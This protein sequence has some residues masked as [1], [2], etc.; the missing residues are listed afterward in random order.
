MKIAKL[1]ASLCI[2]ASVFLIGVTS[3]S[4]RELKLAVGFPQGT[5]AYYGLEVFGK[6]LK[7]KSGGELEV[8]LFPLSLLNHGEP[9][10]LDRL[11]RIQPGH[12]LVRYCV[13]R[14]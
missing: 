1:F 4:A 14:C 9:C 10:L 12:L 6:T 13:R 11:P 8:K 7:E 5:A 3:A 2:G